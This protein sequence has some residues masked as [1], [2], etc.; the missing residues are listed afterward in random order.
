MAG[1]RQG[2]SVLHRGFWRWYGF[3]TRVG[4]FSSDAPLGDVASGNAE[5]LAL[6]E[7]NA[8]ALWVGM[9]REGLLRLAGPYDGKP[10]RWR[11][12][13]GGLSS[14]RVESLAADGASIWVGSPSGLRRTSGDTLEEVDGFSTEH[15][16]FLRSGAEGGPLLIGTDRGLFAWT[17]SP[18][19]TRTVGDQAVDYWRGGREVG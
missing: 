9:A 4:H 13:A 12:G 14:P 17:D 6:A 18:H 5:V 1:G 2:L 10:T 16:R 19:P 3:D 15:I 11:P 7:D 8:G